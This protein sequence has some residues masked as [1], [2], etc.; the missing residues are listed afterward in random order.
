MIVGPTGSGK[1]TTSN[2]LEYFARTKKVPYTKNLK[3]KNKLKEK[4]ERSGKT[5]SKT[6]TP[7]AVVIG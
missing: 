6:Y 3:L 2:A 4:F 7:S 5:E 1:S